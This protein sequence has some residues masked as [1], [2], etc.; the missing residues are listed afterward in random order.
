MGRV[1]DVPLSAP[2]TGAAGTQWVRRVLSAALLLPLF[3][4]VVVWG[5]PW[6]FALIVLGVVGL[7]QW[8]FAAL[9]RRAGVA[10]SP[11]LG[12]GGGLVVTA[13]FLV[14]DA[15]PMALAL[16][17][18]GVLG[19]SLAGGPPIAW[20]PSAVTLLG[21]CYV[22]FL[23][24]H[25]LWLR[26]VPSGM[27]WVLF[28]VAVTW[29]GESAAYAVGSAF[30]RHRLAP[31]LSPRKTVEGAAG[32]LVA[33]VVVAAIAQPILLAE[34]PW[35]EVV[36]LGAVLG[37]VGQVGDLVESL[38]KRSVGAKDS[39]AAIPGHGGILDRVDGLL[40]CTPVLFYCVAHGQAIAG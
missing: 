6:L 34:W 21:I 30:G 22:G 27:E 20:Q 29:C 9:F 33:A 35:W 38:L 24:G 40:F 13:S 3:L 4:A 19:A 8:E 32:Q 23:L 18:L 26:N 2:V 15:V 36:G 7:A 37:V 31:R 25:A 28:L 16:V 1:Q 11:L 17:V 12:V 10:A 39:G 5:P 14:P